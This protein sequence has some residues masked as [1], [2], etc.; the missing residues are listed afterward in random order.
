MQR[1]S[2]RRRYAR[3]RRDRWPPPTR[4]VA[5]Q[6]YK[7]ATWNC[8]RMISFRFTWVCIRP[9]PPSVSTGTYRF[10]DVLSA[11]LTEA[12]KCKRRT[13]RPQSE[14]STRVF[15]WGTH[16]Q[17]KRLRELR[18][19]LLIIFSRLNIKVCTRLRE[20]KDIFGLE[21]QVVS[22][23]VSNQFYICDKNIFDIWLKNFKI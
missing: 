17:Y 20:L 11:V 16:V 10:A 21:K 9:R 6:L 23:F 8:M 3:S 4:V 12:C 14:S 15:L 7:C 19:I 22:D 5:A 13:L 2:D 1:L 18:L